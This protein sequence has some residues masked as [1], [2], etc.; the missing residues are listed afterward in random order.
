MCWEEEGWGGGG[1]CEGSGEVEGDSVEKVVDV[2][3]SAVDADEA[4]EIL[5]KSLHLGV[6]HLAVEVAE[7]GG[8]I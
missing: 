6:A 3:N 1:R 2:F 8:R 5:V 7:D 4:P